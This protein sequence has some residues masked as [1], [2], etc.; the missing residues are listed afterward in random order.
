LLAGCK[1]FLYGCWVQATE[2][3]AGSL[4]SVVHRMKSAPVDDGVERGSLPVLYLL[5]NGPCRASDIASH[6]ALDLSTVS[7]HVS[8]LHKQ[9]LV[10]RSPDPADGRA[11][12]LQV[13]ARG[14]EVLRAAMDQ[15]RALL[16]AALSSWTPEERKELAALLARLDD[17]LMTA[18]SA[19][20]V[21][22]PVSAP[23]PALQ[24]PPQGAAR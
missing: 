8:S 6:L 7:R 3:V 16:A 2:R 13:T 24:G 4:F 15:R 5:R 12:L 17:D 22:Q 14:E 23:H 10:D 21:H 20:T 18:I 1:Q 11:S 19:L 9:G